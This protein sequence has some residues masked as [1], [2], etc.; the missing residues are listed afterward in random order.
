MES[1]EAMRPARVERDALPPDR[2]SPLDQAWWASDGEVLLRQLNS[3]TGGLGTTQADQRL[4]GQ[5]SARSGHATWRLFASQ[6][7]SPLVLILIVGA[8]LSLVLSEWIDAAI[9]LAI[10]L[11]SG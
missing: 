9:I 5:A 3:G 11:G 2:A 7:T 6:F 10:V 1:P 8:L 4:S